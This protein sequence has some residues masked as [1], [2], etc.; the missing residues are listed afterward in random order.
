MSKAKELGKV[1]EKMA[2]EL[3]AGKGYLILHKNFFH[4]P[5]EIDI[6][7][8]KDG[9]IVFTEV[10]TRES[11]YLSDPAQLVPLSKQKQI[12]RVADAYIKANYPDRPYRFDIVVVITNASY[13]RLEHIEDAFYP[14]L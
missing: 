14:M 11:A 13:T 7:S 6:I 10:K 12:I 5:G 3:L 9:F 1:G 8:D 4:P 2:A